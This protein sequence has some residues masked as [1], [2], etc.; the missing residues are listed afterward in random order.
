M[1]KAV[2]GYTGKFIRFLIVENGKTVIFLDQQEYVDAGI[3]FLEPKV[4][5][6]RIT[7]LAGIISNVFRKNNIH[8]DSAS[9][10]LDSK[11]AYM[12]MIPVD[13]T[14]EAENINSSLIWELSNFYP[15]T[16]KN[17]K[18]SYQKIE[19]NKEEY[20]YLGNTLIIAYHK[21][22][23]EITRRLS[24]ISSIRFTGIN[25]DNFTAGKF[26][27]GRG[28]KDFILLG[29]KEDRTD[30]S[31]YLMG[32]IRNYTGLFSSRENGGGAEQT[33]RLLRLP[34]FNEVNKIFVYGEEDS[35]KNA[36]KIKTDYKE[37]IFTDPFGSF[38]KA[39]QPSE[40]ST[41]KS[42]SFTPLFG[43]VK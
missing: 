24:E 7:E 20:L 17:F 6:K 10:V 29:L 27:L 42:Y 39:N 13:F 3:F 28:E 16:Y 41:L 33:E 22:I 1:N 32:E 23:A 14:D 43:P 11:I 34:G 38:S 4:N 37:I 35:V 5:H 2:I 25:F 15:D 8:V 26:V 31:H 21:N 9:L 30:I 36:E 40:L 19:S 12:N 18:I